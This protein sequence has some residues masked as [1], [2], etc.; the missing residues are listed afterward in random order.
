M[1]EQPAS[2]SPAPALALVTGASRG[3]GRAIA[4]ELAAQDLHVAVNY[5]SNEEAAQQTLALIEERGGRG[6]L[7]RFDVADQAA[8]KAALD[9]LFERHQ[10]IAALVNNAGIVADG[11]F[12][13]MPSADWHKVVNTSLDGFFNV[14]KPVIQK[15]IR[16][17]QGSVVTISSVSGL[18]GN[19]GQANYAAAKAGLMGASRALASEVARIG[20]RVNVVAPGIIQTDMT[21]DLPLDALKKMIPMARCGLPEEVARVVRFLCSEDASYVT[22]QIIS[23]NGGMV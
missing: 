7:C 12:A 3:I 21:K 13:M 19:R 18:I 17:R 14:T 16:Q 11:L 10:R 1:T 9:A 2:P 4:L 23:V 8:V 5:Q 6:E 20:I 22:G 15:M